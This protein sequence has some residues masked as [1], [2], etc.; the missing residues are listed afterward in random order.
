[1]TAF[2]AAVARAQGE[3]T[4]VG[5]WECIN[6]TPPPSSARWF[7]IH[8][9]WKNAPWAFSRG[10]P[11]RVIGALNMFASLLCIMLFADEWPREA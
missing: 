11:Y 9:T 2:V 7:S 5:G 1:M 6:G 8:L 10:D 3:L 4:V